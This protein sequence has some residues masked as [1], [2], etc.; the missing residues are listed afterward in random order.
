MWLSLTPSPP[1]AGFDQADKVGHLLSYGVLMGW[2]GFLHART[3]VRLAHALG[4]AAMGIALEI[5]QGQLGYR[6]YE[7]AD[8]L[9]NTL[10]VILG[11]AVAIV[12][13]R[14]AAR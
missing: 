10:G 1:D 9:A 14:I 5:A 2:F 8:M 3:P 11:W 12:A 6:S 4:F 7:V 13:P